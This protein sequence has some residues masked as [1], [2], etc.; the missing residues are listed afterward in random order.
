M[1]TDSVDAGASGSGTDDNPS[2]ARRDADS[3]VDRRVPNLESRVVD[4]QCTLIVHSEKIDD[5]ARSIRR[6]Q[7]ENAELEDRIKALEDSIAR[8]KHIF[9]TGLDPCD[10][11]LDPYVTGLDPF[12]TGMNTHVT[13]LNPA[14]PEYVPGSIPPPEKSIWGD[15]P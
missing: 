15:A 6:I 3:S 10:A 13:S 12:A 4:N 11:G 8:Y 2:I 9:A 7:K 5:V 14:A 1:N